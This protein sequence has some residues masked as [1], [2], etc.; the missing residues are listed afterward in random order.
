MPRLQTAALECGMM[1]ML[2]SVKKMKETVISLLWLAAVPFALAADA[3]VLQS[4]S[5]DF[6]V[7]KLVNLHN[8]VCG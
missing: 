8:E 1:I 7:A 5:G 2:R 6:P 4:W 3:P